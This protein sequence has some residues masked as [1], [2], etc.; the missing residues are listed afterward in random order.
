MMCSPVPRTGIPWEGPVWL[1]L[2]LGFCCFSQYFIN[3]T[4][5]NC[6][7]HNPAKCPFHLADNEASVG[8]V[9]KLIGFFTVCLD[10][11]ISLIFDER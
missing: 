4:K 8:P 5:A 2:G 11:F 7:N 1:E 3:I 9:P 6:F 10:V